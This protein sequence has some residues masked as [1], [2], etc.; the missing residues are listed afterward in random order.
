MLR[1]TIIGLWAIFVFNAD[2]A[3]AEIQCGL[4]CVLTENKK[5]I[6]L[7]IEYSSEVA[8]LTPTAPTL[9]YGWSVFSLKQIDEAYTRKKRNRVTM[10]ESLWAQA[11][12]SVPLAVVELLAPQWKTANIA[13]KLQKAAVNTVKDQT[14]SEI[15]EAGY[16]NQLTLSDT[17]DSSNFKTPECREPN[18]VRPDSTCDE[19]ADKKKESLWKQVS[20]NTNYQQNQQ[21]HNN[22]CVSVPDSMSDLV[23]VQSSG[24]TEGVSELVQCVVTNISIISESNAVFSYQCIY[25]Q[26]ASAAGRYEIYRAKDS[27]RILRIEQNDG[28]EMVEETMYEPCAKIQ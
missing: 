15:F 4:G 10:T 12:K 20:F 16:S 14:W 7:F 9:L 18:Q 13:Q 22:A 6:D 28:S 25:N 24:F 23:D 1:A 19:Q 11:N 5:S 17:N 21:P 27:M 8:R 2:K 26:G 3:H